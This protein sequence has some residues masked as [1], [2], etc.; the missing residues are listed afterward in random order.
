[1]VA[2]RG[3]VCCPQAC[4]PTPTTVVA[5]CDAVQR[6]LL[7]TKCCVINLPSALFN[8]TLYLRLQ[9]GC[10]GV[11]T[12]PG[13]CVPFACLASPSLRAV[14]EELLAVA[15]ERLNDKKTAQLTAICF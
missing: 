10:A 15:Q 11:I 2:P 12:A 8:T 9:R 6:V 7:Y 5:S 13:S 14:Q 3:L 1:M 4:R